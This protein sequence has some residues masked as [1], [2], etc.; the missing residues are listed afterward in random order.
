MIL[1]VLRIE[2][3][4]HPIVCCVLCVVCYL[5]RASLSEGRV[6]DDGTLLCSYHGWRWEGDGNLTAVPV[7]S[8]NDL[9]RIIDN[10][11]SSCNAFP[12]KVKGGLLYVWPASGSDA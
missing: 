5:C 2:I 11:K 8:K 1:L 7:A 12:T 10:P 3:F 9:Q 4:S 6:E